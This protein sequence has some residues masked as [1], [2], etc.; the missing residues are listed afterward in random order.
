M[1][2]D[3][4][5]TLVYIFADLR[6]MMVIDVGGLELR[7]WVLRCSLFEYLAIV[8]PFRHVVCKYICA[9]SVHRLWGQP[10]I[11]RVANRGSTYFK[12]LDKVSFDRFG[13]GLGAV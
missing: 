12:V 13:W 2:G 7:L 11:P 1:G 10:S 8:A 9:A 3:G 5:S 6:T 4:S